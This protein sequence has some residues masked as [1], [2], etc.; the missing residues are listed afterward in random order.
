MLPAMLYRVVVVC[1]DGTP[2]VLRAGLTKDEADRLFWKLSGAFP[3]AEFGIERD[4]LE[5]L[6]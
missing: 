6:P 2:E 4:L 3:D 5:P 1:A